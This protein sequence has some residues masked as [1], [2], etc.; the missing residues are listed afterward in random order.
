MFPAA[1]AEPR[2][3]TAPKTSSAARNWRSLFILRAAYLEAA[4]SSTT[5][6]ASLGSSAS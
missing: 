1:L 2:G 6:A 4:I 3:I 5:C